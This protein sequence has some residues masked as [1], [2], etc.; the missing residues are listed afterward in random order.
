MSGQNKLFAICVDALCDID[1]DYVKTLPNFGRVLADGSHIRRVKPV[2]PSFTYPCHVSIMSG[3][4]PDRH[5]VPHNE[6]V[7]PGAEHPPWYRARS[8]VKVPY[9]LDHAKA[10]GLSTC[11]LNWPLTA[12]ADIDLNMP[13]T[14]PLF[15]EGDPL[16]FYQGSSTQALLDRYF[17]KHAWALSNQRASLDLFTMCVA[18][19]IIEDYGQPDVMFVKLCDLDS[20]RH[21]F[22]VDTVQA[23]Q[24]LDWHDSQFGSMLDCL[25]RHGDIE[26]TNFVVTGDH[27]Q[28][29][30]KRVMN[31]NRVLME[32]GLLTLD[33]DGKLSGWDAYCHSVGLSAWIQLRDPNDIGLYDRVYDLLLSLKGDPLFAI[34]YVFTKMEA[35][36]DFHLAGPFDFIIESAQPIS[37]GHDPSAPL[38]TPT[39]PGD[40]KTA[41][42]SHGGLPTRS[43]MTALFA[44][45]PSIRRGVEIDSASLVDEA[46]TMARML[47]FDM[48]DTDGRVLTE[49]LNI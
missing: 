29:D 6:M 27:G 44:S 2:Y 24:A 41:P 21:E 28:S 19:D 30:V 8:M 11:A 31:F 9:L 12:G 5:G 40:Y 37:F 36:R 32:N 42:A 3:V 33:S 47:G 46:P 4:Y 39:A 16:P 22:G 23:R 43:H 34:D 49:L 13:M 26:R 15:Y 7:E 35:A 38:F 25:R 48:P 10:R 45:G 1:I 18:L 20:A 14:L 17:R